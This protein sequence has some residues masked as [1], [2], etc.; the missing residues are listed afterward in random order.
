MSLSILSTA[1]LSRLF[2]I[3]ALSSSVLLLAVPTVNAQQ[4]GANKTAPEGRKKGSKVDPAYKPWKWRAGSYAE[5]HKATAVQQL[6]SAPQNFAIPIYGTATFSNG[7]V[8]MDAF[9][10]HTTLRLLSGDNYVNVMQWYK[11]ALKGGGWQLRESAPLPGTKFQTITGY[12]LGKYARVQTSQKETG[13]EI[14]ISVK[15]K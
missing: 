12:K 11:A 1:S 6:S 3:S 15:E 4:S 13:T 8:S 2:L 10:K 9:G 5:L 7:M 14:Y